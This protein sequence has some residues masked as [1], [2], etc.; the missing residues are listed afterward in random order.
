MNQV[1]RIA[2]R[3][4]VRRGASAGEAEVIARGFSGETAT[5]PSLA[6]AEA[7]QPGPHQREHGLEPIPVIFPPSRR[8]SG[9]RS[10]DLRVTGRADEPLGERV[11]REAGK[12]RRVFDPEELAEVRDRPIEIVDDGF[13]APFQHPGLENIEM[14][15][16]L[17]ERIRI[18]ACQPLQ[19]RAQD[20]EGR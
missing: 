11:L 7:F 3:T 4:R 1:V 12:W 2:P 16:A 15:A 6:V 19:G 13:V 20:H 14:P 18:S 8:G 9:H 10:G 17:F 5:R